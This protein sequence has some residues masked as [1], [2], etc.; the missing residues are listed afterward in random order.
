MTQKD[1]WPEL[2]KSVE[3]NDGLPVRDCGSWTQTKLH[4]WNRYIDI[5]T[6][7]MVGSP[8]WSAIMYV[9]LFAGPGICE[10]EGTHKRLPGSPLIAA[11]APKSFDGILLCEKDVANAD[12]CETRLARILPTNAFQFSRGDCNALIESIASQIPQRALTLAFIDPT[13]LHAHFEMI[14]TLA[15]CGRVD[16]LILFADAVDA[17]RN[18]LHTYFEQE[19]SK[20]DLFL[21][22]NSNWRDRWNELGNAN[23]PTVRRLLAEIYKNQLR[24]HLGYIKF[25]EKTIGSPRGPLYRLIY[26]SKHERGLEFWEKVTKKD[27][28]GQREMF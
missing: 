19:D 16:L 25:G 24:K 12:A 11:N 2:C 3:E 27:V 20:L 26:A 14:R 21:G 22:A 17:G 10:I 23:G 28:G 6:R 1:R 15:G 8:K 5:T 9:D 13:G 18:A 4:F 7:A